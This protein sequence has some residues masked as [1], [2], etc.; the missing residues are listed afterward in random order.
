MNRLSVFESCLVPERL[1]V[2]MEKGKERTLRRL[3]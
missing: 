1:K 2:L 3:I